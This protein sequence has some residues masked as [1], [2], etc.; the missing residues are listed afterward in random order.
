[1]A[2]FS[3]M[4]VSPKKYAPGMTLMDPGALEAVGPFCYRCRLE[5]A[6]LKASIKQFG[7]LMPVWV[8]SGNRP[9]VIAG[10]R[11]VAA[12]QALKMK[13]VPV[14]VLD[15]MPPRDAFLLTLASNWHQEVSEM[16]RA[17]A[18]G[19]ALRTFGFVEQE[20]LTGI[21]PIL[22]LS[23][24]RAL[25][26]N[27]LKADTFPLSLKELMEEG[28]LS[29]RG[30]LPLLKFSK[31]DQA[32]FVTIASK[33][34]FTSSQ[35]LQ[36]A[37]WLGDLMKRSG[38]GLRALCGTHKL[39]KTLE[40]DGMDPRAKADRF[41]ARIKE[42]RFPGYARFYEKF[43]ARKRDVLSDVKSF[44]LE[45]VQG[46][47]EPGLELHARVKDPAALEGLLRSLS[48]KQDVLNSLFEIML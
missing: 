7:I 15:S 4:K 45:P 35:M 41:L 29:F 33:A 11:R 9:E 34:K 47:E 46:F 18:L 1:M 27:Y 19:M 2:R 14:R 13:K 16:D 32:F 48:A 3:Q 10:H 36:V 42:L 40:G 8:S 25:L 12:A 6:G 28:R 22:G 30:I 5:D 44:R 37:D 21:M 38:K 23:E 39:L 24:E 20:I 26:E 43:E 17:R 31:R